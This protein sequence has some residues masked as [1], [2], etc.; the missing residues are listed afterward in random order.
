MALIQYDI[1][2]G[3]NKEDPEILLSE[4]QCS[5]AVNVVFENGV[6]RTRPGTTRWTMILNDTSSAIELNR[7]DGI[8]F[9]DIATNP[10]FLIACNG[11]LY[12]M[13]ASLPLVYYPGASISY[14]LSGVQITGSAFTAA[15]L[16]STALG[17][18]N[19]VCLACLSDGVRRWVP[20]TVSYT[21]VPDP[22]AGNLNY[23]YVCAHLTRAIY[24]RKV[25]S[26]AL[27]PYSIIYSVAGDEADCSGAGSGTVVLSDAIG[28]ICGLANVQ[29]SIVV[30]R[31]DGF[32]IGNPTG[33]SD[34]AFTW[35]LHSNNSV[36]PRWG[37][38]F[39]SDG[40]RCYFVGEDDVYTF[41]LIETKP[42]GY[43]IR[44]E[45]TKNLADG[46]RYRGFL[47]PRTYGNPRLQYHLVPDRAR[48][49]AHFVYDIDRDYW[50]RHSYGDEELNGGVYFRRTGLIAGPM[51]L[52]RQDFPTLAP[53]YGLLLDKGATCT[54]PAFVEGRSIL[55]THPD[56]ETTVN[57]AMLIY[58]HSGPAPIEIIV[59]C[60][61]VNSNQATSQDVSVALDPS[62]KWSRKW[63]DVRVQGA[64]SSLRITLPYGGAI[65][66]ASIWLDVRDTGT[67]RN[68]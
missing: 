40:R 12:R 54:I 51:I 68:S 10:N 36:G 35:K 6:V 24:A 13:A 48:G 9:I 67:T 4:G 32:H 52:Q 2:A 66:V 11:K 30:A 15:P 61:G 59:S 28:E 1:A 18:V 37:Y 64:F 16:E 56:R 34:P 26:G 41:D 39:C 57:R 53:T 47:S 33:L 27:D 63:I 60:D 65:E 46:V 8:M 14:E 43:A 58:R 20:P 5:D 17:F 7:F 29:G 23:K 22:T 31:L 38:D 21:D 19:G 55:V 62:A 50:S 25:G 44:K 49:R 42:I 3:L 45:L